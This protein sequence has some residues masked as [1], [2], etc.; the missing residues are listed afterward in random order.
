MRETI[1][2]NA[3]V[4]PIVNGEVLEMYEGL[5]FYNQLMHDYNG[6]FLIPDANGN[7]VKV[8]GFHIF[9]EKTSV[10]Y[11][12]RAE[13]LE[14]VRACSFGGPERGATF[15]LIAQE[16]YGKDCTLEFAAQKFFGSFD[17]R[18]GHPDDEL[19]ERYTEYKNEQE[20]EKTKD[21]SRSPYAQKM[22]DKM[23]GHERSKSVGMDI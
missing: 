22:M 18:I 12:G 20:K 16:D 13:T 4:Q 21:K 15:A 1:A 6:D 17:I 7:A 3:T 9:D 23:I 14:F 5:D 11:T 19:R 2:S 10:D 8:D